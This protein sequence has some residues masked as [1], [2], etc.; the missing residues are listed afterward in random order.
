[1]AEPGAGKTTRLPLALM[2]RYPEERV[3]VLQPRRIAAQLAA[4]H[5][6]SCI[7]ENVGGLVGYQVRF[8]SATSS[9]TRLLFMTEGLFWRRLLETPDLPEVDTIVFDEFHERHIAADLGLALVQR[10]RTGVR[11][12]LRVV[13]MSATLA[14]EDL[15]NVL[16][17]A[18]T[19]SVSGRTF[20]VCI[21]YMSRD[22]PRLRTRQSPH[23]ALLA[24]VKRGLVQVLKRTAINTGHVL[25]FLPGVREIEDSIVENRAWLKERGLNAVALHGRLDLETQR[26]AV[27]PGGR[28]VIFS[29]NVAETSL[30][31]DGVTAVIDSGLA[32]FSRR[33][34]QGDFSA[35]H[36]G[37]ISKASAIQRAG[38]AGRTAA[39]YCLRLYSRPEF[40]QRPSRETPE[41]MQSD[42]ST[43]VLTLAAQG[44]DELAWVDT[45]PEA[46]LHRCS[47]LLQRL[48]ALH[49]GP[50]HTLTPL[51]SKMLGWPLHPRLARFM[52]AAL[53]LGV[54][55]AAAD[56]SAILSELQGE[57]PMHAGFA[58]SSDIAAEIEFYGRTRSAVS[59][60]WSFFMLRDRL[61]ARVGKEALGLTRRERTAR[62]SA[63]RDH[64]VQLLSQALLQAFPDRVAQIVQG[65][66]EKQ[67][68]LELRMAH[69][70]RMVLAEESM[71]REVNSLVVVLSSAP[72][73]RGGQ[74]VTTLPVATR[75]CVIEADWLFDYFSSDVRDAKEL[76]WDPEHR[77]VECRSG[78]YYGALAIEESCTR[79]SPS[80]EAT[81][82]LQNEVLALGAARFD[83]EGRAR[84]LAQRLTIASREALIDLSF[85]PDLH[86]T[87]MADTL[88]ALALEEMC[89]DKV[90]I[91]WKN[92]GEALSWAL[93]SLVGHDVVSK[94][95]QWLP[96]F[97]ELSNGVRLKIQY[98]A[99][100][101]VF[102][103]TYLQD[104]FGLEATPTIADG[105]IALSLHLWAPNG[106][107]IQITQYLTNFWVVHYPALRRALSRRYPRH[108]WPDD[109]RHA[110]APARSLR[111]NRSGARHKRG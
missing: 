6:A 84:S 91:D 2:R 68:V 77:R 66:G 95:N 45:P 67:G 50:P 16:P 7:G 96:R 17:N 88:C 62:S 28:R 23:R 52:E 31:I 82:L 104:L 59:G 79:A 90:A 8:D 11:S 5:V 13:V 55:G 26:R 80:P 39:G 36:K 12:T 65:G 89:T 4:A 38:R 24:Q 10:L 37:P 111:R 58:S 22:T 72:A 97:I 109:P 32:R 83:E 75:L 44:V 63:L 30:T 85:V 103:A 15:Q 106:R 51:G 70:G 71:V 64:A 110:S 73:G 27:G 94:L 61:R 3:W 76:F 54:G 92:D 99:E 74:R 81:A 78:L 69:G 9:A 86:V 102:A 33:L 107:P 42:L 108:A 35:L 48:G 101:T 93:G 87:S 98:S 29:T 18:Y 49:I 25:V 56:A 19:I 60:R 34:S 46:E 1:M 41:I 14:P 40:G 57:K 105:R 21:E 100:G 47:A 20:P 53:V 43:L